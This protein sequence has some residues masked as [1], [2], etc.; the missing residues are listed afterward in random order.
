MALF[1]RSGGEPRRIIPALNPFYAWVTDLSWPII[2]L[3]AGLMLVAHGIPKWQAGA[4]AF[5]AGSL[6]RRGIEPSLPLAYLVI[7]VEVIGGLCIALG[8]FTRFFA[9]AAAIHLLV[10]TFVHVPRGFGWSTGGYEYPLF[11]GLILFAT[12]LRGGGPYS[13]D[14]KIGKEL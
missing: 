2:R 7:F 6:A 11:W 13:V 3:T 8:L 14:R 1:D 12:A 9:A 4:A 5:A 10:V